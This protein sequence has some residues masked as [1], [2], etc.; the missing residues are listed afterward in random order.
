MS[1][2]SLCLVDLEPET[3]SKPINFSSGLMPK[4]PELPSKSNGMQ[5]LQDTLW[6]QAL[7]RVLGFIR[8]WDFGLRVSS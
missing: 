4:Q 2:R 8:C 3:P 5:L 1:F 7:I 6:V